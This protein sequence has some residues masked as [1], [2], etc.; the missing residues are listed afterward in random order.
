L[1]DEDDDLCQYII[2]LLILKNSFMLVEGI[3]S[4]DENDDI[5][6]EALLREY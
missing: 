1:I 2:Y 6:N 4:E 5:D 3:S